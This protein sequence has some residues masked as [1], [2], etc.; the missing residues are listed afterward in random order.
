MNGFERERYSHQECVNTFRELF[1]QGFAGAD[2]LAEIAPEG[3]ERSP[4]VATFHPSLD[5]VFQEAILS[6]QNIQEL[7]RSR[8]KDGEPPP[9]LE[10][11]RERFEETPVD[12]LREP[13]ELVGRCVWDIFSDNHDVLGPDNRAFDIGS[14]RG[15]GGFIADE[16]NRQTGQ[17]RYGYMDFFMGT[18]WIMCRT[19]VTVIY[20]M[21]FKRLREQ[22]LD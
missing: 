10:E 15:A 17:T 20:E 4:L 16:L 18:S 7:R 9:A 3:W 5:Q 19:N 11:V 14:F 8:G 1:P 12:S 13:A 6:H 21:I 2:V 22:Q